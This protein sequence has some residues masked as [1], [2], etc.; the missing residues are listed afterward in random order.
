MNATAR[1]RQ[2]ERRSYHG[3][4][5]PADHLPW[6][7]P[8]PPPEPEPIRRHPRRA[9]MAAQLLMAAM[10][11]LGEALGF[12]RPTDETVVLAA[13]LTTDDLPL[14]FGPLPPLD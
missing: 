5:D 6:A 14:G 11:G 3:R 2:V 1:Y 8:V 13:D 10:V 7:E 4:I 12:E 9:G